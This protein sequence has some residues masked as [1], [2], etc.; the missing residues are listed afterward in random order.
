VHD[1]CEIQILSVRHDYKK[2]TDQQT[3]IADPALAYVIAKS[4]GRIRLR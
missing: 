4:V 2:V 1:R 3:R